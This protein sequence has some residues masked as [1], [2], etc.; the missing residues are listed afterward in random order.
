MDRLQDR[1]RIQFCRKCA[2]HW[3]LLAGAA[4]NVESQEVR[5]QIATEWESLATELEPALASEIAEPV[6]PALEPNA[7]A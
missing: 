2:E 1:D 4:L 6:E 7:A 3:R 5:L